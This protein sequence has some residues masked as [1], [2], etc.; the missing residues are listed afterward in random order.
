MKLVRDNI[1]KKFPQHSYRTATGKEW[2][3]LLRLKVAEE[4]GEV[5]GARNRDELV[6]ELGDLQT[7]LWAL[8]RKE[9]ISVREVEHA[10]LGKIITLGG[11]MQGWVLTEYKED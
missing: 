10:L 5:V 11:F 3:I 4:A 8:A 6:A 2:P 1:P 7:A 9:G